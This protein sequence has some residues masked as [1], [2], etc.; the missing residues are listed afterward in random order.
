MNDINQALKIVEKYH[1]SPHKS[2]PSFKE[3]NSGKPLPIYLNQITEKDV[4]DFFKSVRGKKT[5]SSFLQVGMGT[6]FYSNDLLLKIE[7]VLNEDTEKIINESKKINE[8][9]K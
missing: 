6:K 8:V 4:F 5:F 2:Y 3:I 1:M 9:T 7:N